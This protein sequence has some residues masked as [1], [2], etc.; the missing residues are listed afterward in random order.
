MK[1]YILGSN[2]FMKEMV[3]VTDKLITIGL[4][5]FIHEDYREMVAGKKDHILDRYNGGEEAKI[6]IEYDYLRQHYKHILTSDAILFVNNTKNGIDNYIGGNV[7][8]EMGQA[9][10]NNKKIFFLYGVPKGLPYMDE[11]QA[12]QPICLDGDLE[13]LKNYA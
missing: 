10:V 8:I 13:K 6:K 2:S 3:E 1:I 4:D 5:A 7:L 12:M 9:H 11:I